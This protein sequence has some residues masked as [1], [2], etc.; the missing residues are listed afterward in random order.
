MLTDKKKEYIATFELGKE[1]DT[2]DIWG[3]LIC[4]KEVDI[5]EE[6]F[7]EAVLSFIGDIEQIPPM[8]SA[9]KVDGKK[10]YELAREG[11]EQSMISR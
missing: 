10:L 11:K 6:Q 7:R 9:L 1:T 4:E 3:N 2:Q 8:Y 5:T